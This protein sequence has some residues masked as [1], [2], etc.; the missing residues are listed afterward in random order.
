MTTIL[1]TKDKVAILISIGAKLR[2][3]KNII[4]MDAIDPELVKKG[5]EFKWNMVLFTDLEATGASK[6]V[7]PNAAGK[8]DIATICYTSGTTGLPK[9]V[10]LTHMNLLSFAASATEL[11]KRNKLKEFGSSDSYLSYLPLAHV[12][13]RCV[14]TALVYNG[15]QIGFYQGDTLK[16]LEDVA[17]LKPTIFASVPRLYNRIYDKVMA[18][19]N[20]ASFIK[21]WLFNTAYNSKKENLKKGVVTHFL[22]DWLVFGKV[23]EKLGGRVE[24][25]MSGAAPISPDVL[26][27]LR[28]CF[29]ATVQEGYGQTETSAGMTLTTSDDVSSGHVG[30]PF[31]NCEVKLVDLPEMGYTSN[32]KPFPRGEICCRGNNVFREYYKLPDKTGKAK[33]FF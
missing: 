11:M 17:E 12:F 21:S 1:A 31:P 29:S 30:V 33:L 32:D 22:W 28:I 26:D 27:F 20:S 24:L 25:M 13:E 3:L 15:A 10:V 4:F 5:K 18:G 23:R 7:E 9:G 19:V 6:S 2:T 14:V 16:L 8:D